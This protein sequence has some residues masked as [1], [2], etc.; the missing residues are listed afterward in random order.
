MHTGSH[1]TWLLQLCT[2]WSVNNF[3][4]TT[5]ISPQCCHL[6]AVLS[7][8][9]STHNATPVRTLLVKVPEQIQFCLCVLVYHC[10]HVSVPQC[11]T[12]TLHLTADVDSCLHF[13]STS[14][15]LIPPTHRITHGE[16]VFPVAAAKV[17]N[18]LP[19]M[20]RSASSYLISWQLLKTFLKG[21][22]VI[23]VFP[24]TVFC[25]HDHSL[26]NLATIGSQ[27]VVQEWKKLPQNVVDVSRYICKSVQEQIGPVF[28]TS[29][30]VAIPGEGTL[31]DGRPV[32]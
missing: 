16:R 8:E 30:G 11:L 31:V 17:W 29:P 20:I 4:A 24:E 12:E 2:G 18:A 7:Q 32:T 6:A 3:A 5:T 9:F 19:T 13:S 27:R 15:L 21:G 25:L 23:E 28:Y 26:A 14:K 1:Q 10:L 22:T